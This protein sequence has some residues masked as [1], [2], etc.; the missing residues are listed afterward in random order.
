[1]HSVNNGKK[2]RKTG[3]IQYC[4]SK[5]MTVHDRE[6]DGFYRWNMQLKSAFK[7][8]ILYINNSS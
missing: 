3:M 6:A 7:I 5:Y 1:M 8:S 2:I 4:T